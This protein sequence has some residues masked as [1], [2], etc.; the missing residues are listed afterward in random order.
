MADTR[1][2]FAGRRGVA[3]FP[4]VEP[5]PGAGMG[6]LDALAARA[7][8]VV[9]DDYPAFILPAM[10]AGAASR[11]D[12]SV[13]AVDGNGLLPMRQPAGRVFPT[14][15]AFRRHLQRT[16]GVGMPTAPLADPL[17]GLPDVAPAALSAIATRYRSAAEALLDGGMGLER[18]PVDHGV[19]PTET[20]GGPVAAGRMLEAFLERTVTR[21]AAERNQVE[22]DV[23]SR[24]SG[25]SAL[26]PRLVV[27]GLHAADGARG[28]ARADERPGLGRPRGM[29]GR[30]PC[31]RGVSGPTDH[32]ARAG[33][34]HVRRSSGRLRPLRVAAALG[35]GHA[36]SPSRRSPATCARSVDVRARARR[37][38]RCGMRPRGSCFV[39]AGSTTIV[40]MLWGKKILEWSPTPEAALDVMIEL[41]NNIRGRWA[42]PEHIQRHLLD[43][44]ALRSGPGA[45]EREIF[46]TVRYMSSENTARKMPVK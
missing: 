27:G 25:I 39:R 16:F 13:E 32:L 15:Y 37:T 41:N 6:L 24:L 45:P 14:A 7:R 8:V 23:S 22:L 33:L 19:R 34:Q 46:G 20:R 10:A 9:T 35:A 40:R 5:T 29:V 30:Q 43:S 3:Y 31:G 26:R 1:A 11:L 28:L 44:R 21:Y 36:R 38:I 12:V 18:L 17:D 4:W 2:A 42:R